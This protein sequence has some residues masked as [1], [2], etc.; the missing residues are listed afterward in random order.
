[1]HFVT[2]SLGPVAATSLYRCSVSSIGLRGRVS[3]CR[4]AERFLGQSFVLTTECRVMIVEW[5]LMENVWK[6]TPGVGS[7]ER[8]V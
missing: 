4:A 8:T 6:G 5:T 1:M 3:S 2:P 7:E